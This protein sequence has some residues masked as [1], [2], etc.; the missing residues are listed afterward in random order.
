MPE[1][2][3][4]KSRIRNAASSLILYF[5]SNLWSCILSSAITCLNCYPLETPRPASRI[6]IPVLN[7]RFDAIVTRVSSTCNVNPLPRKS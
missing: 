7:N 4:T 5:S 1:N 6:G 3:W 2:D